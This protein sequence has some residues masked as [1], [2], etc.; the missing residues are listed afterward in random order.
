MAMTRALP[1]A[2]VNAWLRGLE[3]RTGRRIGVGA[4][5]DAGLRLRQRASFASDPRAFWREATARAPA[6]LVWDEHGLLA[7]NGPMPDGLTESVL[8]AADGAAV[9]AFLDMLVQRLAQL[10]Y[11]AWA[12]LRPECEARHADDRF[13]HLLELLAGGAFA[14]PHLASSPPPPGA[15]PALAR[16]LFEVDLVVRRQAV[17][18]QPQPMP[19]AL[20]RV[21]LGRQGIGR[22]VPLDGAAHGNAWLEV[23]ARDLVQFERLRT[24]G[25][26]LGE[27]LL[28]LARQCLG[29]HARIRL[30]I[31]AP[32]PLPPARLGDAALGRSRLAR[33]GRAPVLATPRSPT[34]PTTP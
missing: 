16:R 27:G 33:R 4:V 8:H 24:P 31:A 11:R 18:W 23:R 7:P 1:A 25:D 28:A 29:A 17:A 2:A 20:A 21:R 15:L 30:R 32:R 22:R 3:G 5:A 10:H 12:Q 6:E 14:S 13:R 19:I 9:A 26:A 34:T